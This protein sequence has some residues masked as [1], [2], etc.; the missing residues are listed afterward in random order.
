MGNV[1]QRL[2]GLLILLLQHLSHSK[3]TI[4]IAQNTFPL[5]IV[6]AMRTFVIV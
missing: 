2:R 5:L 4:S 3:N 1:N 6:K